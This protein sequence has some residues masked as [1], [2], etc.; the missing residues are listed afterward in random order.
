MARMTQDQADKLKAKM[1]KMA[2]DRAASD[3]MAKIA[4]LSRKID[5]AYRSLANSGY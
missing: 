2:A 5:K 4:D 1:D 3:D